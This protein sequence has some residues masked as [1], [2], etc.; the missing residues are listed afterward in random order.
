MYVAFVSAGERT[1]G[2]LLLSAC[3]SFFVFR[4]CEQAW[5]TKMAKFTSRQN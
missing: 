3:F 5:W 1:E 2:G 4:Q